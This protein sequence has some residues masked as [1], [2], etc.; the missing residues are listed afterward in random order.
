M[1]GLYSKTGAILKATTVIDAPAELVAA[2][3]MSKMTRS[4]ILS[5]PME[6]LARS[7]TYVNDHHSVYHVVYDFG[8]PRFLPRE[9]VTRIIWQWLNDTELE[10]C[11]VSDDFNKFPKV[12]SKV[13][14]TNIAR[15]VY[16]KMPDLGDTAQTRLTYFS[17][18][19]LGGAFPTVLMR[20]L[21]IGLLTGASLMR[22]HFD[23]SQDIDAGRRQ[24]FL[25]NIDRGRRTELSK[26]EK[27]AV[28]TGLMLFRH[29]D[30]EQASA[31]DMPSPTTKARM[32]KASDELAKGWASTQVKATPEAILAYIWDPDQRSTMR[33]EVLEKHVDELNGH[34]MLVFTVEKF[35]RPHHDREYLTRSVWQATTTGFYV[36]RAPA[37]S[38]KRPLGMAYR[39]RA[40]DHAAIKISKISDNY[41]SVEFAAAKDFGGAMK[42]RFSK[43]SIRQSLSYVTEIQE[44]FLSLSGLDTWTEIDGRAMGEILVRPS[45]ADMRTKG[46]ESIYDA[47]VHHLVQKYGGLGEACEQYEWLPVLLSRVLENKLRSSG[48]VF[49][50]LININVADAETI[51]AGLALSLATN[52]SAESAVD[53]WIIKYLAL[54]ELDRDCSWFR[55]MVDTVAQRLLESVS[56]GV[57]MRLYVGAGFSTMDL[58]SDAFMVYSFAASEDTQQDAWILGSMFGSCILLQCFIVYMQHKGGKRGVL[59]RELLFVV[60]GLKPG[61]DASRVARNLERE[62]HHI[63]DPFMELTMVK[64]LEL[65]CEAIPGTIYMCHTFLKNPDPALRTTTA[66][67]IFCSVASAGFVCASIA[68]DYD[69]NPG[70]RRDQ[71]NIYGF[72][73]DSTLARSFIFSFMATKSASLLLLRGLTTAIWLAAGFRYYAYFLLGDWT[74]YFIQKVLRRD[75]HYCG[76]AT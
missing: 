60:S 3:E 2:W 28:S 15:Y 59:L 58:I 67:S 73:P 29:F 37:T 53:E 34:S 13:R 57:K 42:S 45:L 41:S 47:R 6:A 69:V 49:T 63:V 71:P 16:S 61:V 12:E 44:Y 31:L 39:V 18:P 21:S 50:K 35:P 56:W 75:F 11:V 8:I 9:W 74:L 25:R 76:S 51:G 68:F 36:A 24:D 10:V 38:E 19:D 62:K 27:G 48:N 40:A 4:N 30:D 52:L 14:A 46:G 32:Y 66:F 22:Q 54:A 33:S 65:F 17:A 20:T 23:N 55:P 70:R 72:V 26:A 5:D 43:A 64:L 1:F 7:I